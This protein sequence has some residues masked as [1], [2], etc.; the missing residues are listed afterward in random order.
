[1]PLVEKVAGL[2]ANFKSDDEYARQIQPDGNPGYVV[3]DQATRIGD[4]VYTYGD[5][6]A[7]VEMEAKIQKLIALVSQFADRVNI[8]WD[9]FTQYIFNVLNIPDAETYLVADPIDQQLASMPPQLRQGIKEQLAQYVPMMVQ[10]MQQQGNIQAQG[11][12]GTGADQNFNSQPNPTGRSPMV[13][14]PN[15]PQQTAGNAQIP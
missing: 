2:L 14:R 9:K 7:V 3:I 12:G 13:Q 4:Y 8:D 11:Q 5:S 10:Q 15:I 6:Q 1:M